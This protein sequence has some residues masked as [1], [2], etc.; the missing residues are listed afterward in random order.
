[1]PR[2]YQDFELH[3][4]LDRDQLVIDVYGRPKAINLP[5]PIRMSLDRPP[6]NWITVA[7]SADHELASLGNSLYNKIFVHRVAELF[8]GYLNRRGEEEGVRVCIQAQSNELWDATWELLCSQ[9]VPVGRFMALDPRTPVIRIPRITEETYGGELRT[10]LK[11]LV[12]LARPRLV[13]QIDATRERSEL[14][15]VFQEGVTGKL[16]TVDYLGFGD[17]SEATFDLLQSHIANTVTQYDIV[18][19]IGHGLMEEGREGT[20]ALV[21]GKTGKRKDVSASDLGSLFRSRGVMLVILQSCY[22]G[23]I[24]PSVEWVSSTAPYLVAS[25]VPAVLAMQNAIDQDVATHFI[26]KLYSRWFAGNSFEDALTQARQSVKHKF[27]DRIAAWAMPVLYT[28]AGHKL[29]LTKKGPNAASR[30]R[31]VDAALPRKTRRGKET[32]LVVMIRTPDTSG[33]RELLAAGQESFDARPEDVESSFRFEVAF[34]VDENTG[35]PLP[36]TVR[37]VIQSNEFS[38]PER[39]RGSSCCRTERNPGTPSLSPP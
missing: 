21:D 25:G 1:M 8:A 38:I 27:S 6:V 31:L 39:R 17:P 32:E 16:L 33:L 19:V 29:E 37:V 10:P 2:K 4:S 18:H 36:A 23:A 12:V 15:A 7:S 35:R 3:L 34:E 14:E 11:V 20:Q 13:E 9:L 30:E 28:C 5:K 22:G 26:T 24:D